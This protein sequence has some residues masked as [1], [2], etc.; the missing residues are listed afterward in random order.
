MIFVF[1]Y[2]L[3]ATTGTSVPTNSPDKPE[4]KTGQNSD[5]PIS[6]TIIIIIVV[7]GV[8]VVFGGV[9][10]L[11]LC[12]LIK[13][14]YCNHTSKELNGDVVNDGN[15]EVVVTEAGTRSDKLK[16]LEDGKVTIDIASVSYTTNG[17]VETHDGSGRE[18]GT[19]RGGGK[20]TKKSELGKK[21]TTASGTA[22]AV[23]SRAGGN[24]AEKKDS[25][26]KPAQSNKAAPRNGSVSQPHSATSQTQTRLSS[27]SRGPGKPPA[28][29]QDSDA[30][31][32]RNAP[33]PPH[34]TT[35]SS[36]AQQKGNQ[37]GPI[38]STSQIRSPSRTAPPPPPRAEKDTSA[39]KSTATSRTKTS[40]L[41]GL[42]EFNVY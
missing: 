8:V 19:G 26:R 2:V 11:V 27:V 23:G 15:G 14:K 25:K 24:S 9:G 32:R 3:V 30:A 1:N 6:Q 4:G 7:V 37:V 36:K 17:T 40:P 29:C 12:V 41:S 33:P 34:S 38:S 39:S 18:K 21:K 10:G 16:N 31:A 35:S 5:S 13:R 22:A 20:G 28:G 42:N